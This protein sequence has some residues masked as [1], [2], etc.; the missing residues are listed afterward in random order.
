MAGTAEPWLGRVVAGRYRVTGKLGRGGMGTEY[1]AEHCRGEVLDGRAD[2]YAVGA[3]CTSCSWAGLPSG[4][5]P[6]WR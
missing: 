5:R 6:P 3:C 2:L 4:T 1:E